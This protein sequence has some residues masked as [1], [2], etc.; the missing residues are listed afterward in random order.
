[1]A[2][3]SYSVTEAARSL[4]ISAPTV[5]RMAAEGALKGFRTPGGHLRITRDSLETVRTG[6]KEKREAQGPSP[7]LRNRRERVEELALEAQELRAEREIQRLRQEQDE[8]QAELEAEAK[9]EEREAE[10]A[11]LQLERVQVQQARER[12]LREAE[13]ELQAFRARWLEETEKVLAQ[14]RLSWLSDSQRRE[15]LSTCEAEIGKRQVSDAPRMA[16]IIERTISGTIE[17]WDRKRQIEKLRTDIS[18][19]ALWKLPSGATDPEKAQAAS[20]IRQ[21]LEK[22]PANAADFELRAVAEEAIARLWRAV[23]RREL[24]QEAT[25]WAAQQLPW[26]ATDADK[27]SLRR[28]CLEA[29]AELPADVCEAEAREHLQDLV[30]EATKEIEDREAEKERERRKPQLVT[31][32]VSQVFCYLLELKREGEISSEEAWDSEL[33]QELE[34]AVREG[35]EDELSGDETPKEVQDIARQ[36]MDDELE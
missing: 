10:A 21:A 22:L 8:A 2:R 34:Q 12:E 20:L 4:G 24:V 17:P 18:T 32:G 9:A 3:E 16:V 26:E 13:R 7:V 1:M 28:E 15:V 14:Y 11:R 36:I 33:R 27:N 23:K 31:L 29:L 25:D 5:R 30:E 6:T 19:V 35:L